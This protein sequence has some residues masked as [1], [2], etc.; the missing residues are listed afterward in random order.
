MISRSRCRCSSNQNW[1]SLL[2]ILLK[3]CESALLPPRHRRRRSAG[4]HEVLEHPRHEHLR[5][6]RLAQRRRRP[7]PSG[8]S[9]CGLNCDLQ[10][11]RASIFKR[12][13]LVCSEA[14]FC[15]QILIGKRL[16]RSTVSVISSKPNFSKV[17]KSLILKHS[18]ILIFLVHYFHWKMHIFDTERRQK[19]CDTTQC[20]SHTERLGG[21]DCLSQ[22]AVSS[23]A[24]G[25]DDE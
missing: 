22:R 8:G 9:A 10:N 6:E 18:T 11:L 23:T 19:K 14:N 4:R 25:D 7:R 24:R 1:C 5:R 13:V 21:C 15:N 20:D 16:M 3:P 12:L 2:C 17:F